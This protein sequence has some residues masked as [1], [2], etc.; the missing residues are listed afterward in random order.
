[1]NCQD[2]L[3]VSKGSPPASCPSPAARA[4][5]YPPYDGQR[6]G[7]VRAMWARA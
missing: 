7:L 2:D 5:R 3:R 4:R 1:M 6:L